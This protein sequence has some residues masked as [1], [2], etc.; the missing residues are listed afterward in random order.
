MAEI[1]TIKPRAILAALTAR[2][3]LKVKFVF[4]RAINAA[5]SR[6][7]AIV[8]SPKPMIS[9]FNTNHL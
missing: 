2:K 6:T 9:F 5:T 7:N 8:A 3:A 1:V 4:K